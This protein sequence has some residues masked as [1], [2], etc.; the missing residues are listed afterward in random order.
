[1]KYIENGCY[2]NGKLQIDGNIGDYRMS[3]FRLKDKKKR[4][5]ENPSSFTKTFINEIEQTTP[6]LKEEFRKIVSAPNEKYLKAASSK[7][8]EEDK[9]KP[10]KW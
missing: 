5:N 6:H 1:M 7:E 2:Q 4:I 8:D 10:L 9:Y 3:I